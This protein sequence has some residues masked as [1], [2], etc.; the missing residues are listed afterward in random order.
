MWRIRGGGGSLKVLVL[1]WKQTIYRDKRLQEFENKNEQG[2]QITETEGKE[3]INSSWV[4]MSHLLPSTGSPPPLESRGLWALETAATLPPTPPE[5]TLELHWPA[6]TQQQSFRPVQLLQFGCPNPKLVIYC[7]PFRDQVMR[8][9]PMSAM[10]V[11][12]FYYRQNSELL[13]WWAGSPGA[14]RGAGE[15][16]IPRCSAGTKDGELLLTLWGSGPW[17]PYTWGTPGSPSAFLP[18]T[19]H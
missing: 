8:G 13:I 15:E 19:W 6:E 3:G 2:A 16:H 1:Y 4:A 11:H 17:P 18:G 7:H 14:C 12:P 9:R 5:E 10:K